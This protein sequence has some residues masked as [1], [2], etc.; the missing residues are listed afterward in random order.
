MTVYIPTYTSRQYSN[1][2]KYLYQSGSYQIRLFYPKSISQNHKDIETTGSNIFHPLC[3]NIYQKPD[4]TC[5]SLSHKNR[6]PTGKFPHTAEPSDSQEIH[7]TTL[8]SRFMIAE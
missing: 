5:E 6:Q 8:Y 4:K 2:V 7:H 1:Q 3:P